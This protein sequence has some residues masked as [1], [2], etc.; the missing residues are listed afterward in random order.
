MEAHAK[1]LVFL[2]TP[3]GVEVAL[4]IAL[5]VLFFAL[6]LLSIRSL[7]SIPKKAILLS[8]RVLLF[9]L[10]ALTLL[11]PA[12]RVEEYREEKKRLAVLIDDSYS[13]RLPSEPGGKTRAQAVADFFSK[14]TGFFDELEGRLNISYYRFSDSL[15]PAS[16]ND[17]Y[18]INPMG[19][20]TGIRR[21]LVALADEEKTPPDAV[22]LISDGAENPAG[23]EAPPLSF[24]VYT[25][26]ALAEGEK[27]DLWVEDIRAPTVGF[28]RQ[29][30]TVE[31]EIAGRG[32]DPSGIPVAIYRGQ[33][34]ITFATTIKDENPARAR[35]IFR[36]TPKAPGREVYTVSIPRASGDMIPENN[37]KS[38]VVDTVIDRIRILHIAGA[39]S[40]DVRFLRTA[41]KRNPNVD[42]IAF[43]IL[44]ESN[45]FVFAS[46][47]E[48]SLIPFPVDELFG[49]ELDTIDIVI[50]QN[51]LWAPYGMTT[52]HLHR[53]KDYVSSGGGFLF[54]GGEMSSQGTWTPLE[55]ILPVDLDGSSPAAHY[56]PLPIKA[57]L[58]QKGR[59]HPIMQVVPNR[60]QNMEGWKELRE[61]DGVSRA[62]GVKPWASTLLEGSSGEPLLVIGRAGSGRVASFLSDSS[63]RW[64]FSI[65]PHTGY[66]AGFWMRLM[67]WLIGDPELS[68]TRVTTEKAV[69]NPG[70]VVGAS[71]W[72]LDTKREAPTS[73]L[74]R[75]GGKEEELHLKERGASSFYTKIPVEDEG[76]YIIEVA[77]VSE[78]AAGEPPKEEVPRTLFLV[79]PPAGE[80]VGA[81]EDEGMLKRI[82]SETGG[83]H[84]KIEDDPRRLRI[85]PSPKKTLTGYRTEPIW[86]NP[87]L[88]SFLVGIFSAE[89]ALRRLW[90]LR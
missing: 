75:P 44:R 58:T 32:L 84:I 48:L 30:I 65:S 63:W 20:T 61:L 29:P 10:L 24:P 33:E 86:H 13:M 27:K 16:R 12:I 87:F 23:G 41:L 81:T 11:N 83:R 52:L 25:V 54:I 45:D 4:L 6:S 17:A 76:I 38:F 26:F 1:E 3:S 55:E 49:S 56:K 40:W 73:R 71:V 70:D 9:A 77:P 69:Y 42:L 36:I 85:D 60:T 78:P 5:F 90:G 57:Q 14:N 31:V 53:L 66:H 79:E 18:N 72:I 82:S 46:Q 19:K 37:R 21:A 35:A 67:R 47:D 51:F 7:N 28:L 64:G 74:I 2:S 8:L 88:F 39:P 89:V 62:V 50:F 59:G 34:V 43:Y 22:I 15:T 80:I 68:D